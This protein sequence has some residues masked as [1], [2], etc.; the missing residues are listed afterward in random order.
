MAAAN[1][2][3]VLSW[4]ADLMS[5]AEWL[6]ENVAYQ[7][8]VLAGPDTSNLL[9]GRAG[10]RVVAGHPMETLQYASKVEAVSRFFASST[11]ASER[12]ELL[13]RWNVSYVLYGPEERDLGSFDP[14]MADWAD[15]VFEAG[16][17][18]LYRVRREALG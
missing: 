17:V 12:V 4:S 14:A 13:R 6:E 2:V 8:T 5:A 9:A 1:H 7:E 15:L 3:G 11:T 16:G 10:H 18:D